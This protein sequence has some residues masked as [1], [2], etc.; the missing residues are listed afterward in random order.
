[1]REDGGGPA[2]FSVDRLLVGVGARDALEA[3]LIEEA[4][5]DFVWSGSLAVSA[6][7]AVPDAS[8]ISMSQ[9]LA[10][11]RSMREAVGIP[12]LAD[13][14]T[15]YGDERNAAYAVRLFEE[16]GVAGACFEDKLFPKENSLLPD[17]RQEL[18]PAEDF[19][20]KI[21]AAVDARRSPDFA[22]VARVEAL[23]AGWG[24]EEALRRAYAY[25]DAGADLILIHSR[26][27]EPDEILEFVERWE[28]PVPLVLVPT[29]YPDL[30]EDRLRGLGKVRMV[31]YANQPLRAAV[32]AQEEL[33][34]EIRRAGGVHTIDGRIV[35]LRRIFELQES[36]FARLLKAGRD[37]A[38][39]RTVCSPSA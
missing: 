7:Y 16:A 20:R 31:V 11:A 30:T 24:Q 21:G 12:V 25:A 27:R 28:G 1:M 10:A 34:R 39:G 23:I 22:V 14:D 33:L 9:F 8:L 5:F 19:A 2:W 6:S 32:R 36:G 29:T 17:G 35:S 37:L 38:R 4:G 26:R 15:G 13:C 18:A 3:R